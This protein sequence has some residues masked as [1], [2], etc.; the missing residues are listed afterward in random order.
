M[1][2]LKLI[3]LL[4]QLEIIIFYLVNIRVVSVLI[5]YLESAS[6]YDLTMVLITSLN[7]STLDYDV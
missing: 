3:L 2:L 4:I 5:Q 6:Q 7:H 1:L